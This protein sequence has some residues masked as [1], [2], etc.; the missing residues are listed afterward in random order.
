MVD[1]DAAERP[2]ILT[3][4]FQFDLEIPRGTALD[5][6]GMRVYVRFAH[7]AAPIGVQ[8]WRAARRLLLRRFEV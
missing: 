7:K 8:A 6:L 1:S 4:V 5:A 2:K 3:P